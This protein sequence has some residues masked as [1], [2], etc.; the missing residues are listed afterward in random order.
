M[1][2]QEISYIKTFVTIIW[3][4]FPVLFLM[5]LYDLGLTFTWVTKCPAFLM[6]AFCLVPFIDLSPGPEY[7]HKKSLPKDGRM[8][9]KKEGKN[10]HTHFLSTSLF[11]LIVAWCF[12]FLPLKREYEEF[13]RNCLPNFN[14][15]LKEKIKWNGS[16][17][18]KPQ[19]RCTFH[20][21][22]IN[23]SHYQ[24]IHHSNL[25]PQPMKSYIPRCLGCF[26]KPKM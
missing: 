7:W 23:N 26:R 14:Y 12:D 17:S 25:E 24:K 9:G 2:L 22:N 21:P 10:S 20:S 6:L 16:A 3:E 18:I 4:G 5:C 8:I 11:D 13:V 19:Y 1:A 15:F